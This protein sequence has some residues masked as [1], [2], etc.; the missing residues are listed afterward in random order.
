MF[1]GNVIRDQQLEQVRKSNYWSLL[2]DE[3]TDVSITK[4]LILHAMYLDEDAKSHVA[5]LGIT[6]VSFFTT[7]HFQYLFCLHTCRIYIYSIYCLLLQV[8]DGKS[9]TIVTATKKFF[10]EHNLHVVI[11]RQLAGNGSDGAN[12]MVG[13]ANGDATKLKEVINQK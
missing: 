8:T 10:E 4:Q 9:T 1:S 6:E 2:L 7:I 3:T 11:R 5:F 12:V 13:K